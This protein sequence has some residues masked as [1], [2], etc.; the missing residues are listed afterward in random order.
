VNILIGIGG[1]GAK[2]VE[3]ALIGCLAGVQPFQGELLVGLIDQDSGNGNV[4]RTMSLLKAVEGLR[5]DW[6]TSGGEHHWVTGG[7]DGLSLAA[8]PVRSMDNL[9][10]HPHAERGT[11][12][13]SIFGTNV[14]TDTGGANLKLLLDALYAPDASEQQMELS[15]GYRGRPHIGAAAILSRNETARPSSRAARPAEARQGQRGRARLPVRLRLRRHGRR[16]LPHGGADAAQH[17]GRVG[18]R[19][20]RADRRRAHAALLQ[21]RRAG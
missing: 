21:L 13:A 7:Q 15:E 8:T 16:G 14:L 10:W 3:S 2:I 4:Q 9:L 6:I 18:R 20:V 11:T 19:L 12:L 1:T 17:G 5:R